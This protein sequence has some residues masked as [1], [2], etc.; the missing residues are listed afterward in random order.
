MRVP[1]G[2]GRDKEEEKVHVGG[3]SGG[4]QIKP[5]SRCSMK[6]LGRLDM[7]HWNPTFL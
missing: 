6:S 5:Q 3:T 7:T 1:E 2:K 4:K